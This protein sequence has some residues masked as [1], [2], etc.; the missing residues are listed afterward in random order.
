MQTVYPE[1]Q[2]VVVDFAKT[3]LPGFDEGAC[4]Y[5]IAWCEKMGVEM[6][7]GEAIDTIEEKQIV[8]KSGPTITADVVYKCVGVM[9]NTEVLKGTMFEGKGFRGSV[10]VNDFLQIEGCPSVYCVGDMMSHASRELKL[11]HTAEVNGHLVAHNIEADLH[12]EQLAAYPIGTTG[13]EWT[14]KIYCLSLGKYSA[15]LAFNGLVL[16]GW[17]ARLELSQR[18]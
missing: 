8:L 13:A 6:M 5:S 2:V 3:I 15:V 7:L 12:G 14:P 11:G 17:C 9:P 1:K 4:K 16:S 18:A 10:E